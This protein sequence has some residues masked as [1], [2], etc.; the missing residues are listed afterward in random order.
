MKY[1]HQNQNLVK[2]EQIEKLPENAHRKRTN[3]STNIQNQKHIDF[4][5]RKKEFLLEFLKRIKTVNKL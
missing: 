3:K 4:Y 1:L 5:K 2:F